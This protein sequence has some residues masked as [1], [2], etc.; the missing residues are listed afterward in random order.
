MPS[1]TTVRSCLATLGPHAP[2]LLETASVDPVEFVEA[3]RR[4]AHTRGEMEAP[5]LL[6]DSDVPSADALYAYY[7]NG[8]GRPYVSTVGDERRPLP[9][10]HSVLRGAGMIDA[11]GRSCAALVT[12]RGGDVEVYVRGAP[13]AALEAQL[14]DLREKRCALLET[15]LGL[16]AALASQDF[17]ARLGRELRSIGP[18]A[19]DQ[20]L[21]GAY[22]VCRTGPAGILELR[23]A[24]SAEELRLIFDA[25]EQSVDAGM[26]NGIDDAWVE[27]HHE[28]PVKMTVHWDTGPWPRWDTVSETGRRHWQKWGE[29]VPRLADLLLRCPFGEAPA[30]VEHG[31]D[32]ADRL[33]QLVKAVGARV[34]GQARLRMDLLH[35]DGGDHTGCPWSEEATAIGVPEQKHTLYGLVA[36]A[37]SMCAPRRLG[38]V[39]DRTCMLELFDEAD[40]LFAVRGLGL[41]RQAD[42]EATVVAVMERVAPPNAALVV[43]LNEDESLKTSC[44]LVSHGRNE[45]LNFD[46]AQRVLSCPWA[47]PLALKGSRLCVLEVAQVTRCKLTLAPMYRAAFNRTAAPPPATAGDLAALRG[48]IESLVATAA[49]GP[50]PPAVPPAPPPAPPPAAAPVE[51]PLLT[52]LQAAMRTMRNL[53]AH[54]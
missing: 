50:P 33:L 15:W 42:A 31:A 23:P 4:Q 41:T 43:T 47:V 22:S 11:C 36:G 29:C 17:R 38:T 9:G 49:A 53:H 14:F 1:P 44:R 51:P 6:S 52:Q 18:S 26:T 25:V 7:S 3:L 39:T 32:Y 2:G 12:S 27:S 28:N 46:A 5:A 34:P 21:R 35:E 54:E 10:K 16:E 45:L 48:H 19:L 37:V 30:F 40:A 8:G 24:D 20:T 13:L